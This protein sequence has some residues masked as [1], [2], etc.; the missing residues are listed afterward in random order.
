MKQTNG[1]I[2]L[3]LKIDPR[4]KA[5]T[6]SPDDKKARVELDTAVGL[7]RCGS[8]VGKLRLPMGI[9]IIPKK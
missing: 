9:R 8:A 3:M 6:K 4:S 5:P 7:V 2:W 1:P